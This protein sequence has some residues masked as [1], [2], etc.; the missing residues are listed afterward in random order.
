LWDK[1]KGN[2]EDRKMPGEKFEKNKAQLER[3]HPMHRHRRCFTLIELL[4]VIS[5]IS[6]L[7]AMLLPA[8]R[9][10]KEKATSTACSNNLRQ[11]GV[12][13]TLYIDDFDS[14]TPP[15]RMPDGSGS[16]LWHPTWADSLLTMD[17]QTATD[18]PLGIWQCPNNR[19]QTRRSG[20]GASESDDSYQANGYQTRNFNTYMDSK[21]TSH[22]R[23]DEL[24]ALY[25]GCYFRSDYWNN[26]GSN[27]VPY[28]ATGMRSVRYAHL[29]GVNMLYA[30]GHTQY[31][32]GILYGPN[33]FFTGGTGYRADSYSNGRH[34]FNH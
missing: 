1:N 12:Q 2:E 25:D 5:I 19:I 14:E 26:D 21:V 16:Y 20:T 29:N 24:Y 11:L 8:L 3:S 23:P 10:A 17:N 33:G 34:W 13:L 32:K 7:A 4:V 22:T 27:T 31:L 30:D 28:M 6:I 15:T 18:L 9:Q